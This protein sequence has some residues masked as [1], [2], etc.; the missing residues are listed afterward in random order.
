MAGPS[1]GII[2]YRPET[3]ILPVI[4][5]DFSVIGIVTD[6]DGADNSVFPLNVAV[7]FASTDP[8]YI[9]PDIIGTGNLADAIN[10]INDQ[11]GILSSAAHVVVVRIDGS[12]TA[13]Q[14]MANVVAGLDV[15]RGSPATNNVTARIVICPGWTHQMT[16]AGGQITVTPAAKAGGNTGGGAFVAQNPAYG[17]NIKAGVYQLRFTG[18]GKE[19]AAAVPAETNTG[20]GTVGSMTAQSA[21]QV[22]TW[23]LR[24]GLEAANGGVF[25]VIRPDGSV[26]GLASVGVAYV[27]SQMHLTIADGAED[28]NTGDIF[29]IAVSN[30]IP[31]G[32]GA[33]V[34]TGPGGVALGTGAVGAPFTT[35]GQILFSVTSVAP[36]WIVNDGFDITVAIADAQLLANPVCAALP[37]VLEGMLATAYVDAP[38]TTRNAAE[39]FRETI[40]SDRIMVMGVDVKVWEGAV[41][42]NRPL[43]PRV[44]GLIVRIDNA[45]QGKPF[46][47]FCNRPLY[48]IVG[49]G[50]PLAFSMT[51]GATEAQ[52]MLQNDLAVVVRGELQTDTAIADAGFQ[53]LGIESC[54]EG[55]LWSQI[56]QVRGTDYL[57]VQM[58]KIT[59]QFLG[60]LITLNS[61]EAWLLSLRF[62]LGDEVA[63][64]NIAGALVTF[65]KELNSPE[66]VRLGRLTVVPAIEPLPGFRVATHEIRRYRA[67]IDQLVTAI[68]SRLG[69]VG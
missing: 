49:T 55:D 46:H 25:T 19:A 8:A 41:V 68:I 45:H 64:Q 28:Y 24:C 66:Q 35:G 51:D 32:G 29:T 63:N 27:S 21:A 22:G 53:F 61:A 67:A 42:V 52:M 69:S 50:R 15:L 17:A 11:L 5:F 30:A 6:A 40:S 39:N 34:V 3:E 13:E 4:P 37:S 1:I 33:F 26:D 65:P 9:D 48:G 18:G 56:H 43:S 14:S 7:D 59:R 2:N 47:P 23:T 62:M 58:M 36:D 12:G 16:T 57:T 20:D 60:R 31:A 10:G 54:A 38:A 44:A